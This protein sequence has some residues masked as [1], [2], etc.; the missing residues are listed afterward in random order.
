MFCAVV[1]DFLE[2]DQGQS[3]TVVEQT[4]GLT[5]GIDVLILG[6]PRLTNASVFGVH[7]DLI[8]G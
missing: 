4:V 6:R 2:V 1:G 3:L 8:V 5:E 7:D